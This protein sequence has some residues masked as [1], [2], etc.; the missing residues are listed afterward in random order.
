[1]QPPCNSR[2]GE[3]SVSHAT[4]SNIECNAMQELSTASAN[5]CIIYVSHP[6]SPDPKFLCLFRGTRNDGLTL[7]I[8]HH[9]NHPGHPNHPNHATGPGIMDSWPWNY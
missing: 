4:G 6:K 1:M 7:G 9:R 3:G 5:M 2:F 8:G